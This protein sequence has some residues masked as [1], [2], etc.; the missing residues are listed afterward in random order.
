MSL[1]SF[2]AILAWATLAAP[3]VATGGNGPLTAPASCELH[4][5]GARKSFPPNGRLVAPFV[6]RGT[7]HAERLN[8]L[9]NINVLDP[10]LRLARVPDAAL[11]GLLPDAGSVSVQR[12]AETLDPAQAKSAKAPL[13]S[14]RGD[15]HADLVLM[16]LMD[17]EG[18]EGNRG[19]LVEALAASHGMHMTLV[20]R[21]F[22]ADGRVVEKRTD[23]VS[24]PI[25]IARREWLA[26][27]SEAL[28]A[29][30]RS[31]EAGI[32]KFA[33]KGVRTGK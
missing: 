27:P 17:L 32:R 24:A 31:I 18:P 21:R 2:A 8:P 15:C 13:S 19:L 25:G 28:D 16:D 22:G 7:G 11:A 9:A 4:L 3:A 5:W 23:K 14:R 33:A 12:H 30:D 10:V 6:L 20:W 29:I 26:R 1:G